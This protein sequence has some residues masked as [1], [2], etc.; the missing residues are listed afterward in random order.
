MAAA[1]D[2]KQESSLDKLVI[3]AGYGP[4]LGHGVAVEFLRKG[5]SVAVLSR[6]SAREIDGKKVE[7]TVDTIKSNFDKND[8]ANVYPIK[9]DMSNKDSIDNALKSITNDLK[10]KVTCIVY[11]AGMCFNLYIAC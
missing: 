8:Q 11:N 1:D 9:T 6:F 7:Q 3:V 10:K 4:G 2:Q 5:F